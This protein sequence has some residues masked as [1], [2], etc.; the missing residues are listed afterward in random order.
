[1]LSA[2]QTFCRLS[3]TGIS[4]P[5][6]NS[7]HTFRKR[8]LAR[9]PSANVYCADRKI[10]TLQIILLEQHPAHRLPGSALVQIH[11]QDVS[12]CAHAAYRHLPLLLGSGWLIVITAASSADGGAPDSLC[13]STSSG[14][15]SQKDLATPERATKLLHPNDS[16]VL[17]K[18]S[19]TC[20]SP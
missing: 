1:M 8:L 10:F 5:H 14:R 19:A 4:L 17:R 15:P 9:T 2:A 13:R 18:S 3:S 6:H 11:G 16:C 12:T 7:T 20:M